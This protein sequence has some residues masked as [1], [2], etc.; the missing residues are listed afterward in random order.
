MVDKIVDVLGDLSDKTLAILGV[1]FKPNTDDMR[2]APSLI[3]LSELACRGAKLK[4]YD[5]E[6]H[7]EGKWRFT[8]I[9]DSLT[10]CGNAYEAM[11]NTDA[12]VILTE[13]NEFRNLNFDRFKE[14]GAGD[15]LFDL[16]NIYDKKA[17][18]GKGFKYYGVGV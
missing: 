8:K 18:I 14:I 4:V 11:E 6:G 3:I 17:M 9:K 10:W 16:R 2:D 12:T 5:P 13:W 15:Y 7:K 1:T